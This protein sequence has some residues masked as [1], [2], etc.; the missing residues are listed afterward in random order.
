MIVH[1][2]MCT[3]SLV[4]TSNVLATCI[5]MF[6][7]LTPPTHDLCSDAVNLCTRETVFA[8]ALVLSPRTGREGREGRGGGRGRKGGEGGG[9][10]R[11][12]GQIE[13]R[14]YYMLY[15]YTIKAS[16]H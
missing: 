5:Q 2:S 13:R 6:I 8:L 3:V 9:E 7:L 11:W 4:S 15:N 14:A 10:G 16:P 12:E 1:V